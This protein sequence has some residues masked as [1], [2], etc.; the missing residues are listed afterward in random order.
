MHDGKLFELDTTRQT[1]TFTR[2]DIHSERILAVFRCG[3]TILTLDTTGKLVKWL[4]DLKFGRICSLKSQNFEVLAIPE[5]PTW[6]GLLGTKIWAFYGK[7]TSTL[8]P[9]CPWLQVINPFN[10]KRYASLPFFFGE[11]FAALGP[12]TTGTLLPYRANFV[13]LGHKSVI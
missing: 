7:E 6:V 1:G 5:K 4:P 9:K 10:C 12:V 11:E 3:E 8:T 13:F 2:A